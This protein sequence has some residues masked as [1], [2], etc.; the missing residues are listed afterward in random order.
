M[1]QNDGTG[2]AAVIFGLSFSIMGAL[3]LIKSTSTVISVFAV[4]DIGFGV[5]LIICGF[6]ML[7]RAKADQR[8]HF[9]DDLLDDLDIPG[10][11]PDDELPRPTHALSAEREQPVEFS[12]RQP[13]FGQE[14]SFEP[15]KHIEPEVEPAS[16]AEPEPDRSALSPAERA[17]VLSKKEAELRVEAKRTAAEA[18]KAA[19]E[20]DAAIERARVA[21]D[22]LNKAE[23]QVRELIGAEQQNALRKVDRLANEAMDLSREAAVARKRAKT[24][25]GVARR[26][27]EEHLRAMDEAANAMMSAEEDEFD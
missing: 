4:T 12:G 8:K 1:K 13:S 26:A 27:R 9:D 16:P 24:A 7:Y 21:E 10:E 18:N 23:Q 11:Q 2:V 15:R 17:A 25:A 22:R 20:A 6:V 3:L 5:L 14:L 19:D